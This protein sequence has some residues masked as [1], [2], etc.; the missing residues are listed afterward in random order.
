MVVTVEGVVASGLGLASDDM[1]HEEFDV[2]VFGYGPV[3]GTL[4]IRVP[5]GT[6]V[7]LGEP[8]ARLSH[9][10]WV[11][12]LW[13]A[14]VRGFECHVMHPDRQPDNAAD[15]KKIEVIAPFHLRSR[16]RLNDGDRL[17]VDV[18]VLEAT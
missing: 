15:A 14:R 11:W 6:V 7:D 2:T 9:R 13:P 10:T 16:F 3:P 1:V 12:W 17:A 8:F 5:A 18:E 4:N